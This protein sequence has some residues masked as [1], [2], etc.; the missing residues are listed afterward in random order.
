MYDYREVIKED[1]K[2]YIREHYDSLDDV[3][4][5]QLYDELFIEDSVTG[6]AS[7]AILLIPMKLMKIYL[8]M[9]GY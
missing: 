1:I 3:N 7:G 4:E 5:S 2:D 8:V 9:N 6:N